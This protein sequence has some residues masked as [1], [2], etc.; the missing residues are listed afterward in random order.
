MG[1]SNASVAVGILMGSDSDLAVMEKAAQVLAEFGVGHE[2]RVLSAHRS[3]ERTREYATAAAA[4]G[5]KVII[6]G[7][8]GAAHL[9]GVVAAHTTLPVVAVP[10][11]ATPLGGL[12][13]L[14]ASVQMPTGIPV[15]TVAVGGA[16]NAALLAVAILA[17]GDAALAAKLA[18]HRR[19]LDVKAAAADEKVQRALAGRA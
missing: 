11:N 2:V 18:E 12:D 4:R 14:L 5:L 6:A 15:A 1:Q 3:P 10:L 16:A 7:A 19:G 9:A 13:A 17:L 8:G